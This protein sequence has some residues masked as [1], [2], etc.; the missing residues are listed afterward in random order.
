MANARVLPGTAT[1]MGNEAP[2]P[3]PSPS[4]PSSPSPSSSSSASSSSPSLFFIFPV[5]DLTRVGIYIP[6][7]IVD[8]P[9]DGNPLHSNAWQNP[10]KN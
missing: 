1:T 4:S 8:L 7:T 5:L 6:N 9:N 2:P 3:S 10:V